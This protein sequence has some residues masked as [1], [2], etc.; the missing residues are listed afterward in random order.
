MQNSQMTSNL[1]AKSSSDDYGTPLEIINLSLELFRTTA[2]DLDPFASKINPALP[3]DLY[4]HGDD[5]DGFKYKWYGKML[6]NPPF[7]RGNMEKIIKKL[8]EELLIGEVAEIILITKSNTSSGWATELLERYPVC[9]P[10]KRVHYF[11]N[12]IL[13]KSCSFD[14]MIFYIG[15]NILG[16]RQIFGGK[17]GVVKI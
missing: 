5:Y 10:R 8:D 13:T 16:F 7:S 17:F 12:G 14:S 9:F 4:Y 2:F 11:K 3:A 15:W 6:I 1:T